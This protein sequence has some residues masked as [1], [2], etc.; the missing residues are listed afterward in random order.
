MVII[1]IKISET[2]FNKNYSTPVN[3]LTAYWRD[4]DS[5]ILKGK[6]FLFTNNYRLTLELTSYQIGSGNTLSG[7]KAAVDLNLHSPLLFNKLLE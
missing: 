6:I 1:D 5:I 7:A 4:E 2:C 3:A